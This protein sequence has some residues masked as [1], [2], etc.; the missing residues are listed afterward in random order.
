M[1]TPCQSRS[2]IAIPSL[3]VHC[4]GRPWLPG[5]CTSI[6]LAGPFLQCKLART[7]AH[8]HTPRHHRHPRRHHHHHQSITIITIIISNIAVIIIISLCAQNDRKSTCRVRSN[9]NMYRKLITIS[10]ES[11]STS[12]LWVLC[13]HFTQWLRLR[14]LR[15]TERSLL[16]LT[17]YLFS[18]F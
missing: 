7:H 6:L 12:S 14:E 10:W 4:V 5:P 13:W 3:P 11:C 16:K 8:T 1:C 15:L 2:S 17:A 9:G 18:L